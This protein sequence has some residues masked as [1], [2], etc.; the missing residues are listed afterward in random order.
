MKCTIIKM[1][2]WELQPA[3]PE[4]KTYTDSSKINSCAFPSNQSSTIIKRS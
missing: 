3:K 4:H 2:T 1:N